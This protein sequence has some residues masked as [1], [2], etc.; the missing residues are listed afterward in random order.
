VIVHKFLKQFPKL[1]DLSGVGIIALTSMAVTGLLWGIRYLGGLQNLE[2]NLYDQMVIRQPKVGPDPRLL[3]V[4]ISEADIQTLKQSTI[5]DELLAKALQNLQQYQPKV[6]GLDIY[7][8]IAQGAGLKQLETQL[9]KP[10]LIAITKM[11]ISETGRLEVPP[12]PSV[13]VERVGFND[14]LQDPDGVVRR[15]L[16]FGNLTPEQTYF[17]FSLQIGITY[18]SEIEANNNPNNPD[19]IEWGNA[20]LLPLQSNSGGYETIDAAGY[21]ILLK[22]RSSNTIAKQISLQQVLAGQLDPNW[23]KDKIVLI[24]YT[25]ATKKDL[26]LTPYSSTQADN[27]KMPGVLVHAQMISQLLDAALGERP[28]FWFWSDG[29]E[30]LWIAGWA[31]VGGILSWVIRHPVLLILSTTVAIAVITG[32][33]FYLFIQGGWV[34]VVT[35]ALATLLTG[36][37]IVAYR[38]YQAQ[39]Q[40]QIVMKLLGQN[41]S[42]E[43]ADALWKNR[44]QLI[45][46]GKLPGQKLTAT[47]LFTDLKD[48]STISEQMPPERLLEWLNEYLG[49]LS[50]TVHQHKGIINKFT[51]DGIMAAFGVPIARNTDQEIAEDAYHAVA[52]ALAFGER[53]QEIN[54][55]WQQRGLP[56][57]QMRVGIF[58]GPVVVGSLGG[59]ERQEYGIIGDSVNIASRLESCEKDRQYSICRVL[60]AKETLIYIEDKFYVEPWGPLALKGKQQMV[61]VYRIVAHREESSNSN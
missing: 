9:Q 39:Q 41:T 61:D 44:D 48:F 1:P 60:I 33:A 24:G 43:V 55:E 2:L 28:L 8:D 49:I 10:N 19:L 13:P 11:G 7:R 6:I 40:Q 32:T 29:A 15:S 12:P 37:L 31:V 53:L 3:I 42:P 36:G 22:Y 30:I 59:N 14:I 27:P 58:T 57:V 23:V 38:G 21:Q 56:V 17:S 20:K 25:A 34:P 5:S 26:F 16:L 47:M 18:L 54:R 52:C 35:P 46:S 4:G 45:K 50:E 51:G